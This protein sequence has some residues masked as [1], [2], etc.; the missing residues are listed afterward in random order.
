MA[1][2]QQ[3][4]HDLWLIRNHHFHGKLGPAVHSFTKDSLMIDVKALYQAYEHI[5][6]A[7]RVIYEDTTL[8][9]RAE[10]SIPQLK[11]WLQFVSP[12]IKRSLSDAAA[13]GSRGSRQDH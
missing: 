9:E 2:L 7:D 1:R 13:I 3:A 12:I 8:E 5:L 4:A 11:Q 6:Y 10:Q